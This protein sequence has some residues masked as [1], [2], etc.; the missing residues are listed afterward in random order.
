MHVLAL[1]EKLRALDGRHE[2]HAEQVGHLVADG[3]RGAQ[4]RVIYFDHAV[5]VDAVTD[6]APDRCMRQ[7]LDEAVVRGRM[8][9][10]DA[11]GVLELAA[12]LGGR[13]EFRIEASGN[14]H[15]VFVAVNHRFR[16]WFVNPDPAGQRG[17]HYH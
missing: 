15:A 5:G 17:T 10:G 1:A 7:V 9:V 14:F 3:D 4:Q 12:E 13:G 16:T 6:R 11:N 2:L 8:E